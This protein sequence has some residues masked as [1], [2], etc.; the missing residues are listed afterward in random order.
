MKVPGLAFLAVIGLVATLLASC[1]AF[2]PG[3]PEVTNSPDLFFTA[4][5]ETII[6]EVTLTSVVLIPTP[7][8]T[9]PTTEQTHSP[10]TPTPDDTRTPQE[11]APTPTPDTL[12]PTPTT[13]PGTPTP[14]ATPGTPAP[15]PTP[16]R[17]LILQD[18]F[19]TTRAWFTTETENFRL[20]YVEDGYRIFN[21]LTG[22]HVNSVRSFDHTNIIVEVDA[23]QISGPETGFYGV[24]CRWQDVNN[25]YALVIGSDGFHGI[26]SVINSEVVILGQDQSEDGIIHPGTASNRITGICTGDTLVLSVNGEQLLEVQDQ[27]YSVGYVGLLVVTR[28]TPGVEVHFA[29]FALFRP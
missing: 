25:Y 19:V 24:V 10:V 13:T 28:A 3:S 12:S 18:D 14:T 5:A 4:A 15:S 16:A 27:R 6:V 17:Q 23:A 22:S 26:A 7:T 11:T 1:E 21:N 20:A 2:S 8:A 9:V 29:D